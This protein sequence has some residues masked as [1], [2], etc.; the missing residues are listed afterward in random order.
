[1]DFSFQESKRCTCI[2]GQFFDPFMG[3]DELERL[4][5]ELEQSVVFK[6]YFVPGRGH[7]NLWT[8]CVI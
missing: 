7:I 2:L 8:A 4:L 3:R 5:H 1:M 6:M